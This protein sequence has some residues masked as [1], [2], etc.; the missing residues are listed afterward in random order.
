M[1]RKRVVLLGGSFDPI[2]CGHVAV[3]RAAIA[4]GYDEVV[5][6]PVAQSPHKLDRPPAPAIDRW[7]MCVLATLPETR[8]FVSRH[9][10]DK[11][12][13]SYSVDTAHEFRLLRPDADFWW[14]IGADN[15]AAIDTWM[16]VDDFVRIARFL[17]VPRGSLQGDA[18]RETIRRLPPWLAASMDVLDMPPADVSS[19]EIRRRI[20][21]DRDIASLVPPDVATFISRYRLYEEMPVAR[22][23]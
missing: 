1:D 10:M 16:R 15:L 3:A 18:L 21:G 23:P 12:P 5:F 19:T 11:G 14:A 4:S 2:H 22:Q 20:R 17:A 7:A 6:L 13:P 8:F 9:E